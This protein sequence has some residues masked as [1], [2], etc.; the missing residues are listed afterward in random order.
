MIQNY[1]VDCPDED[2]SLAATPVVP[3][4]TRA[5]SVPLE[6]NE[7]KLIKGC[8]TPRTSLLMKKFPEFKHGERIKDDFACAANIKVLLQGMLYITD[9]ACYFYSP[10]NNKTII[11]HGTK[12]RIPFD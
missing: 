4:T 3:Q 10:F 11:G 7:T 12:I 2:M 5:K 9:R 8:E 6:L 1:Q